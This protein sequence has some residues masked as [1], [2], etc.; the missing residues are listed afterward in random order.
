MVSFDIKTGFE[1]GLQGVSDPDVLGKAAD[2]GRVLVTH[3]HRTMPRH[4]A[5]IYLAASKPRSVYRSAAN[6]DGSCH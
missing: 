3:D 4:F 5:R 1:A 6:R 2:E